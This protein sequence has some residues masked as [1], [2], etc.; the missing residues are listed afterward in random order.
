MIYISD[1]NFFFRNHS[2]FENGAMGEESLRMSF[3]FVSLKIRDGGVN[4]RMLLNVEF[5]LMFLPFAGVQASV[6]V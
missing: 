6:G 4:K 1:Q 5:A 2:W 3:R